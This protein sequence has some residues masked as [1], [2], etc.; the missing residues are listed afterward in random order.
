MRAWC[1]ACGYKA[2]IKW[3]QNNPE[4]AQQND[5]R[6]KLL[7]PEKNKLSQHKAGKKWRQNNREKSREATR[8]WTI[9]HHEDV[10]K[11]AREYGYIHREQ[12]RIY[13]SRYSKE[14]PQKQ[15]IRTHRRR[16]RRC[17]LPDTFTFEQWMYCLAFFDNRCAVCGRPIGL[18]HTLTQDHW[19]PLSNPNSPGTISTN[20]IPLCH[21]RKDGEFGCNN[22][23][24]NRDALEWLTDKYGLRRAKQ[25][26][27]RIQ[28]YFDSLK[29]KP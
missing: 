1:K 6:W 18:W 22:M 7:N 15:N 20:I 25:I 9:K 17:S 13:S 29:D 5:L 10:K 28:A 8:N 26:A 21:S 2:N 23:K 3:R 11:Y 27:D 14:N 4:R 16:A 24:Y 19:I 12:R